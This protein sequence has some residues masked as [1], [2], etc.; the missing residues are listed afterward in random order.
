M[1]V[2][3]NI[4][5]PIKLIIFDDSPDIRDGFTSLLKFYDDID[6]IGA[7]P[8]AKDVK[9]IVLKLKPNVILMDIDMPGINGIEATVVVKHYVPETEVIILS[10]FSDDIKVI[11]AIKAGATGY[12]LKGSDT[13]KVVAS[14][15][16]V[17]EGGSP[18]NAW[19]AREILEI[20]RKT[21]TGSSGSELD[22]LSDREKEVLECMCKG[23]SYKE[24]G[25]SLHIA[26]NTVRSHARKIYEKLQ[27][28]SKT[29]AVL[30]AMHSK[31]L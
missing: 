22:E 15:R 12:L 27:V 11:N 6:V 23:M 30:K 1:D 4:S 14:I 29:E 16:L 31:L 9:N 10:Q 28:N 7:F 26:V 21:L 25:T 8:D 13:D 17:A 2:Q 24:I 5:K 20:F 3:P 19:V 18:M